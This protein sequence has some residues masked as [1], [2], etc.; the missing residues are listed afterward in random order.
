M[1]IFQETISEKVWDNKYR[2][3]LQDKI[4]D[5]TIE[6]TW[7]RVAK[8]VASVEQ[9]KNADHWQQEFYTILENFR[10]LPGGRILA[11]AGTQ[12]TVTLFNCFVMPLLEDSL[13]GIFDSLKEAALTLQQGGGVGY[14]FSPLRPRGYS[15][16]H[17]GAV[18]SGPVSFMRIWNSMCATMEST[19]ARR[20][21]MMGIL[22]CE[23]PDIEEFIKAKSDPRELRH[24]NVSVLVSDAFM[25]CVKENREWELIFPA[26]EEDVTDTVLRHWS[27]SAEPIPCHVVRRVN[28]RE[29]WEK[30]IK[31]AY[32]YAEPGVLFEDTINRQNNLWY[33]E[34]ISATNPCGE[35][36]LPVYGACNL[37]SINLTQFVRDA[38]SNNAS[39]DW[40]GI[41]TTIAVATRF[42]DNVITLSRYPL[43]M[44]KFEVYATRRIGLGITGLANM[45]VMLNVKYGSEVS[46]KLAAEVMQ[47]VRDATW[48]ASIDLAK[49]RGV[50]PSFH[51]QKYLQGNFVQ[52]LPEEMRRSIELHGIRNSHHNTIAPAGT[53][54]LLANNVSNGIEP[55]FSGDYERMMRDKN[56]EMLKISVTDYALR[57]W[58]KL[59]KAEK[60]PPAWIDTAELLPLQHLQ[61]QAAVQPF[62]D[63]AI[64]KTINLP[65]SFPYAELNEVY[66]Q[67]YALGLKGCTIFRPNEITGSI[68]SVN[69]ADDSVD[70]CCQ[71]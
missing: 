22:R 9:T 39:I 8:A 7:Q 58:R 51:A 14:D 53:I 11:G 15:V 65:E 43:K 48:Q 47:C 45:M 30:I 66:S 23:H 21:A 71:I 69:D 1:S 46:I 57:T 13:H 49:E 28:A 64:S 40:E 4:I 44:Q 5:Q 50:F 24:F 55:I 2:Y 41:R 31:S 42:L 26:Q 12:H 20:G 38:Y 56:S 63:N 60:L 70:K 19:G 25:Q 62:I 33:R 37:G 68:L 6:E 34:W 18:A 67:A 52:Q 3:R 35:I 16:M 17:T 54:S 36:P 32:D 59:N 29:L 10:F 61:M 27:S